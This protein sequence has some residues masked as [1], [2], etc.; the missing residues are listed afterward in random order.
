MGVMLPVAAVAALIALLPGWMRPTLARA[1]VRTAV[2]EAGP[3]EAVI[4]AAGTVMPEVE[5]ILSSPVEA[6]LLRLLKRPGSRVTIGDPVA[7]LDLGDSQL[8]FDRIAASLSAAENKQSQARLALVTSLADIDA[9]IERKALDLEMLESKATSSAQLSQEGLVSSQA[10]ADARLA[11]KAAAIELAQL[12]RER[13]NA[14][15]T[16][17][18]Q[19]EGLSLERAALLKEANAARRTIELATMRSD[20]DGVVTWALT[21]EG[22][23]VRRGEVV[24]RVA[25]LRSFR[26]DATI[27]DVHSGRIRAG[28]P[29]N[30]MAGETPLAGAIAEV[31]PAVEQNVIAFRVQ[32]HD[33]SHAALRPQ[34]RVDVHVVTE[35][36]PRTL[37]VRQGPFATGP[38]RVEAFVVRGNRAVRTT[39]GLGVRGADDVEVVSGLAEGDEVVISDMRDYLHLSELEVR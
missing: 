31:S 9:R 16:A 35:R 38:D 34:L 36:K 4:T 15:R 27:A 25:D 26:V 17:A 10:L 19:A 8:A 23:L 37:R 33:S 14:E 32:L 1:R 21:Q 30:V 3:I 18:L 24:A 20:R 12:R 6:R 5:R 2:V 22:A 29:V 11:A 7:E 39:V 13:A 28:V